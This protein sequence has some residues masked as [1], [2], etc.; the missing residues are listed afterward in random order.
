[1]GGQFQP[2]RVVNLNRILQY[3]N[4]MIDQKID[5]IHNNQAEAGFVSEAYEWRLSI[6]NLD[7]PIKTELL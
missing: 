7:S 5:Y 1:K 6:A 2:A 3:S 4:P